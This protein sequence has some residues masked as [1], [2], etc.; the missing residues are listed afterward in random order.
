MRQ[1]I[2]VNYLRVKLKIDE[3]GV[4]VRELFN[5][6]TTKGID[7]DRSRWNLVKRCIIEYIYVN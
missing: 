6:Y 1:Y 5:E 7:I 3:L 2:K 4:I